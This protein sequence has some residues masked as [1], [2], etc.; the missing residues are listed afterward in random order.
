MKINRITFSIEK[1]G[2]SEKQLKDF[3]KFSSYYEELIF[4]F[5]PT[6]TE[7]G[8]YGF[9]NT[10]FDLQANKSLLKAY[11]QIIESIQPISQDDFNSLQ[12]G[13]V[14]K[15]VEILGEQLSSV[16]TY[17]RRQMNVDSDNFD[18]AILDTNANHA[19]FEQELNVSKNHKNRKLKV[20]ICRIVE[21]DNRFITCRIKNAEGAVLDEFE[22]VK[23]SSVYDASYEFRKSK[24]NG[25]TLVILNRF[26]DE[27]YSIDVTKYLKKS[28]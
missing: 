9:L 17:A 15:R 18:R 4:N 13:S 28:T 11:G 25:N 2:L 27:S 14:E 16:L 22:L 3:N 5:L 10:K 23:D 20:A 6:K 19:G 7:V 1:K 12:N 24:W 26:E 8:G 21:P